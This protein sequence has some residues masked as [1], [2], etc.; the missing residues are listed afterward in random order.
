MVVIH[1]RVV[2]ALSGHQRAVGLGHRGHVGSRDVGTQPELMDGHTSVISW[3]CGSGERRG[4]V[5]G[6]GE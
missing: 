1:Q 6:P 3:G 2:L 4:P 5:W